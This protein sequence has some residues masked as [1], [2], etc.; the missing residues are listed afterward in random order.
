MNLHHINR[1][2]KVISHALTSLI[3]LF[4][5]TGAIA[6]MDDEE[7]TKKQVRVAYGAIAKTEKSCFS[8][9]ASGCD[10]SAGKPSAKEYGVGLGYSEQE[11]AE[12]PLGA[13][14]GLGCGNPGAIAS[15]KEG[16]TVV[17]LGS[18]GGFDC[19]LA[20]KKVGKSGKVI[21]VD[22]TPDMLDLAR[23]NALKG[24]YTNV[25]F[26]Q[27]E[28]EHLPL[29]D[30]IAD[31]IISN[32]VV[33]LSPNKEAVFKEASRV[34]K[35]GGRLAISDVVT[36]TELPDAIK[37]DIHLYTGCITGATKIGTLREIMESAGF[38]EINIDVKEESRNF[39]SKWAPESKAEDYVAAAYISAIK[40]K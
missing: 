8:C 26:L 21:G 39:I 16:E 34:L 29:P 24:G 38:G 2:P 31:V 14:L 32:C 33:N 27:G 19:F 9:C 20:S 28:I 18:G 11:L 15:L 10:E 1:F 12:A 40:L 22:M 25:E 36:T 3:V 7:E 30:S 17:D 13:D 5:A 35:I 6:M 4:N 37:R 23:R